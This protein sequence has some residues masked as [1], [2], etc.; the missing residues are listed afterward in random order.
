MRFYRSTTLA[1]TTSATAVALACL[2]SAAPAAA[3]ATTTADP[4]QAKEEPAKPGAEVVVSGRRVSQAQQAI[5]EDKVANTVGITREALLSAPSGISGLKMLEALPG[6]NVQTD[7]ALGL[8]EFGNSVQTRAFNFD[9]IGFIVDGIPTGRSDVFGGSPVF[10]YVDNE[11]LGSV[12]ASVGA[13]DVSLPSYSSLGPIVQYDSIAPQRTPGAFVSQTFGDYRLR[14]TFIRLSTGDLG[15]VRAFV[16]RTKL[17]SDLWR[18]TGTV[19]RTHW[20]AMLHAELAATAG[21]G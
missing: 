4:D 9:Q 3:Q 5:G 20:E 1:Y 8:Y 21:R 13:G 19:D 6:F 12:R 15:P 14:R 11:N 16:S 18:G 7:G 2:L 17:T 10:R